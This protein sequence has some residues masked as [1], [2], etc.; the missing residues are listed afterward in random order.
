MCN[1]IENASKYVPKSINGL[2]KRAKV[3]LTFNR[4]YLNVIYK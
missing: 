2:L 3:I 4:C 1:I